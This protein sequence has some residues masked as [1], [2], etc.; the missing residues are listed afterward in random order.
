MRQADCAAA[1]PLPL[2]RI[3]A[4]R[5]YLPYKAIGSEYCSAEPVRDFD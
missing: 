1:L 4:S 3:V 2:S 5:D